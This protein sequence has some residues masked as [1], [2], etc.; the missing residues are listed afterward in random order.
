MGLLA[1]KI[2][3]NLC[4]LPDFPGFV[5]REHRHW[6]NC[7]Q[8]ENHEKT[9]QLFHFKYGPVRSAVSDFRDPSG[10]TNVL[11]RLLADRWSSWPDLL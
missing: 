9:H 1:A 3:K 8:D 2:G 4:L 11:Y 10:D 7:L 6:N 5:V